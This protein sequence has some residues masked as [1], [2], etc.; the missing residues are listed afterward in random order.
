[1]SPSSLWSNSTWSP[2]QMPRNG[3]PSPCTRVGE[4]LDE[5]LLDE[6]VHRGPGGADAGEDDALGGGDV[7]RRCRRAGTARPRCSSAYST[8]GA[9]PAR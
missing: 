8:L 5:V 3:T 1:M 4:R 9:F 7:V 2:M 6:R